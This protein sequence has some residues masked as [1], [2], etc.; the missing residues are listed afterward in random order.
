MKIEK[1]GLSMRKKLEDKKESAVTNAFLLL[2]CHR[3][4]V[5]SQTL[6]LIEPDALVDDMEFDNLISL[7]I[8]DHADGIEAVL[9]VFDL[10]FEHL[11]EQDDA[12]ITYAEALLS[13]ISQ[14]TLC[15]PGHRVL[16]RNHAHVVLPWPFF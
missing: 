2:G 14:D 7:R 1:K 6:R 3:S 11:P 8:P 12:F 9:N 15:F 10:L 4:L 16:R 13:A 5:L